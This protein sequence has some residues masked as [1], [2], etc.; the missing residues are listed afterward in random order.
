MTKKPIRIIGYTLLIAVITLI[1]N[2]SVFIH[3][4]VLP[5]GKVI[6]HAHPFD[7]SENDSEP[8]EKHQHTP[9]EFYLLSQIYKFFS[10]IYFVSLVFISFYIICCKGFYIEYN[11]YNPQTLVKVKSPRSPPQLLFFS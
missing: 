4:H 3:T 5:D 2:N 1:I 9:Q 7:L 10:N 6:E 8:D 11:S